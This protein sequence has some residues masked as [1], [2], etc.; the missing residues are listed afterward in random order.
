MSEEENEPSPDTIWKRQLM[1]SSMSYGAVCIEYAVCPKC[2]VP[3][4]HVHRF[5]ERLFCQNEGCKTSYPSR[6]ARIPQPGDITEKH[7]RVAINTLHDAYMSQQQTTLPGVTREEI[8]ALPVE[9]QLI[10]ARQSVA[11]SKHVLEKALAIAESLAE[12]RNG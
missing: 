10:L 6:I 5:E 12:I 4:H 2:H 7:F 3:Q 1:A 9:M 11:A 8:A